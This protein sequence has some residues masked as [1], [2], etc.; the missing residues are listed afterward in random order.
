MVVSIKMP[1]RKVT[2][3][4]IAENHLTASAMI[5]TVQPNAVDLREFSSCQVIIDCTDHEISA[6]ALKMRCAIDRF[7]DRNNV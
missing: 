6:V 5:A 7:R 3:T 4:G 1:Q 2:V